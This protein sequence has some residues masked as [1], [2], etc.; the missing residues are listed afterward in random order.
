MAVFLAASVV[1]IVAVV[2]SSFSVGVCRNF[3]FL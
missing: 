3:C 1:G 2:V